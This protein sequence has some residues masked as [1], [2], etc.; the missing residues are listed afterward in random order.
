MKD[1]KKIY[2]SL[3]TLGLTKVSTKD[4]KNAY[5]RLALK[6]H[7]DKLNVINS[8]EFNNI[9]EAYSYLCNTLA[10]NEEVDISCLETIYTTPA[11][12]DS[13]TDILNG[14]I[15]VFKP[16]PVLKLTLDVTLD[17]LYHAKVKKIQYRVYKYKSNV[18]EEDE[19]YIS[20]MNWKKEYKIKG[21]GDYKSE[22]V[23]GD[24]LVKLNI[25]QHPLYNIDEVLNLYDLYT[26]FEISLLEYYTRK[27]IIFT[28][29]DNE[30]IETPYSSGLK[31]QV[32]K[33]KGLPYTHEDTGMTDRG[34]IYIYFKLIVPPL[35]TVDDDLKQVLGKYFTL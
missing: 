20:L 9:Q 33:G 5:H 1:C 3:R 27:F 23:R 26:E 32:V 2:T 30:L 6:Y 31:V 8:D 7:P 16:V 28:H 29:F 10:E 21:K 35:D 22:N 24:L 34:D 15:D 18:S 19:V 25:V 12:N 17:D 13:L 11:M 4:I 14:L